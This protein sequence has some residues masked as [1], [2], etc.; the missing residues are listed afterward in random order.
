[1]HATCARSL[2]VLRRALA[3]RLGLGWAARLGSAITS[4]P[5]QRTSQ[6][7]VCTEYCTLRARHN[8]WCTAWPLMVCWQGVQAEFSGLCCATV[9]FR[10]GIV[11][12][13]DTNLV[14]MLAAPAP[15]H[16]EYSTVVRKP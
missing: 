8:E 7:H 6:S 13:G 10:N 15:L 2:T 3:L 4:S 11:L 5:T 1:M 14:G 12:P 16:S 9:A